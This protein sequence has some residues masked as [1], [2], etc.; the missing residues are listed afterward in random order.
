MATFTANPSGD[1]YVQRMVSYSGRG[2]ETWEGCATNST[3]TLVD[4]QD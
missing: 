1:G 4:K 2:A 3:G